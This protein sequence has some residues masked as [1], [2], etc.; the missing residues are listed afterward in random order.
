MWLRRQSPALAVAILFTIQAL[1]LLPYPGLQND[2]AL[3]GSLIYEPR[4]LEYFVQVFKHRIPL[5]A[6]SYLG[7]LKSLLYA[8]IFALWP[9]S[10]ASVRVPVIA[11]GAATVWLFVRLLDALLGRRA[12]WVGGLLLAAD[13]SFLLTTTFDWGPVA[14]QHLL[15]LGGLTLLVRFYRTRANWTLALATFLFGLGLW[16]KAV[17]IWTLSGAS[18][19]ALILLRPQLKQLVSPRRLLLGAMGLAVGAAPLIVF[20]LRYHGQTFQHARYTSADIKNKARLLKSSLDG[21]SLFGY[22]TRED[23]GRRRE[24]PPRLGERLCLC[25]SQLA[26]RPRKNLMLPVLVLSLASLVWLRGAECKAVL[27]GLIAFLVA[28]PQMALNQGTGGSTHHAVL[29]WPIPHLIVAAGLSGLS[30][31]LPCARRMFP[32]AITAL[33]VGSNLLVTNE[34]LAQFIRHGAGSAWTD[35]ITSLAG[36]LEAT[37][38]ASIVVADWG[39]LDSLRLLAAGRLRLYQAIDIASKPSLESQDRLALR[40]LLGL[41]NP[42]FVLHT[43]AEEAIPGSGARLA[44]HASRLGYARQLLFTVRDRYRRPIFE[45]CRFRPTSAPSPPWLR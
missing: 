15:L 3:F 10:L 31:R 26:G 43:P 21:S 14:L 16:D 30:Y 8:G 7:G 12:A 38:K 35:A 27:F 33:V 36:R 20:N 32:A 44:A 5:M 42:L 4:N 11:F 13:T 19:S 28:W 39:I 1:L 2:E 6:I 29:L 34:Y 37:S 40:W 45:V 41:P 18:V 17:F 9:P 25:L 22:L 24:D 23:D